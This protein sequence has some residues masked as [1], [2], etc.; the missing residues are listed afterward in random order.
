MYKCLDCKAVFEEPIIKTYTSGEYGDNTDFYCPYCGEESIAEVDECLGCGSWKD[1]H[2]R[3][4]ISCHSYAKRKLAAF[5][6]MFSEAIRE[7]M[8]E[9]LSVEPLLELADL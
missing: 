3:V 7:E 6:K 2:E 1:V 9:I 5:S 4:C 8:D